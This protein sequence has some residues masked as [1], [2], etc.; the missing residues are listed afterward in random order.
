VLWLFPA[1]PLQHQ[2]RK[3]AINDGCIESGDGNEDDNEEDKK[4]QEPKDVSTWM[5]KKSFPAMFLDGID[6][7]SR[8]ICPGN[9]L[10][11]ATL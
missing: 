3:E 11:R 6:P 7:H 10:H 1:F 4:S 9:W 2:N 8:R 5:M